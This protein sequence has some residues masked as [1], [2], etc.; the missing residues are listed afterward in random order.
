MADWMIQRVTFCKVIK[1][2]PALAAQRRAK[3]LKRLQSKDCESTTTEEQTQAPEEPKSQPEVIKME[4]IK[5]VPKSEVHTDEKH[6][7]KEAEADGSWEVALR[8]PKEAP[9]EPF[10]PLNLVTLLVAVVVG[11]T[12]PKYGFAMTIVVDFV[13]C[14]L[15]KARHGDGILDKFKNIGAW[16]KQLYNAKIP[17]CVIIII[18]VHLAKSKL[19]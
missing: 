1:M 7:A 4:V 11:W 9:K 16:I 2:D 10:N 17:A 14:F 8:K 6:D 12:L 18:I 13:F 5:R 15:I 19:F 3:R